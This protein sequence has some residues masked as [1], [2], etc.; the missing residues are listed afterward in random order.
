VKERFQVGETY[1]N[2]KGEFEVISIE[3]PTMSIRWADGSTWEGSVELQERIQDRIRAEAVAREVRA[4]Q[5]R[6]RAR[7]SDSR[8]SQFEGL[9]ESDFQSGV[10]G[11]TWRRREGLGGLLAQRLTDVASREFQSY[12]VPRQPAVHI[13]S[14]SYYD[15]KSKWRQPKFF[16]GLDE[17]LA[18]FGFLIEKSDEPM[19]ETWHWPKFLAALEGGPELCQR[20]ETAMAARSLDWRVWLQPEPGLA[21]RVPVSGDKLVWTPR[22]EGDAEEITWQAFFEKLRAIPEGQWC[23]L[24]LATSMAKADSIAA[25]PAIVE[26]IIAVFRALLPLYEA[27]LK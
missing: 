23:D 2:E 26:P 9:G 17:E 24:N 7:R 18:T 1:H 13:A 25:G 22:P 15:S 20:I 27:S 12:S 5:P 8:G 16:A 19:D 4:R 14:P 21:A 3:G 11:T 10:R 6:R